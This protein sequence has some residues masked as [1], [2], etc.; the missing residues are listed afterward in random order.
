MNK[1]KSFLIQSKNDSIWLNQNFFLLWL[2]N[3]FSNFGLQIYM[4]A[5]PLLIYDI[6]HSAFAMSTMRAVDI[7]PSIFIGV[8]VGV[9]VDRINKKFILFISVII[10]FVSISAIVF[11]ISINSIQIWHLYLLGFLLSAAGNSFW[12]CQNSVVPQI[13]PRERLTEVNAKFTLLNTVINTIGPGIAGVIIATFSYKHS[14]SF[15]SL[16]LLILLVVTFFIK[17][18]EI[19]LPNNDS[20]FWESM[21]EGIN[22]LVKNR[23]LLIPTIVI[24]LKNLANSLII[25]VLIFYLIDTLKA[26]DQQ[27]GY[28]YSLGG[29]GGIIGSMV[30][31][32]AKRKLG[33]GKLFIWS[34]LIDIIGMIGLLFATTW[35][36]VGLAFLVR[37]FG[38]TISNIIYSTI[39]QEFTPPHLLG[40][41]VG[42]SS[43][44]MKITFPLGL[45]LSGLWAE[46]FSIKSLFLSS[47]ILLIS[48]RKTVPTYNL[49]N[50][51]EIISLSLQA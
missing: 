40:R 4:I 20:S 36:M 42:T 10:Q 51:H 22:T 2:G 15:F 27:I 12:T 35:W 31:T 41:I 48:K 6:S 25:G 14:F 9:F 29:I 13:V 34:I 1:A 32:Q 23:I 5:L 26:S 28:I 11:L 24:L 43:M 37:L 46:F 44:L 21:K 33:R 7:L 30:I 8:I 47:T 16:C 18:P 3:M 39:R 49:K 17:L 38:G 50:N 19:E 45:F